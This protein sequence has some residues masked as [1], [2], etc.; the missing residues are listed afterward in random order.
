M[1]NK[2]NS[3][4]LI[5]AGV[6]AF[7]TDGCSLKDKAVLVYGEDPVGASKAEAE[8]LLKEAG[9]LAVCDMFLTETAKLAYV[10]LPLNSF[11]ETEGT[12]TNSEGRI[13]KLNKALEPKTGKANIDLIISL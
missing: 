4:G 2:A 5:S 9:F 10:V 7:K 6:K 1:Q 13:Q 8:K 11:A 12:Y 3:L